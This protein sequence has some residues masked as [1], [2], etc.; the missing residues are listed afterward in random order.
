MKHLTKICFWISISLSRLG[1]EKLVKTLLPNKILQL[2]TFRR[3][4]DPLRVAERN[5][6]P[7]FASLP[8]R[9]NE[10][11]K[12]FYLPS[13]NRTDN[14]PVYSRCCVAAP[15]RP[16]SNILYYIFYLFHRLRSFGVKSILDYSVEED[17]SQEEAEKREVR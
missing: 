1:V 16:Q 9:G 6:A 10:N 7:R 5:S 3:I 12:Y 8:E 15:L 11:I 13:G 17:L 4:L 2:S 14:R